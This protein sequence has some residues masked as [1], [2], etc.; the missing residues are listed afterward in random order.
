MESRV[1]ELLLRR[2]LITVEQLRIALAR[3]KEDRGGLVASLLRLGLLAEDDLT[4]CLRREYR[5]PVVD[6]TA[7][8]PPPEVLRLLPGEV[9]RRHR[10]LPLRREGS[11]LTVA[12]SDPSNLAGLNEVKFLS[13]CDVRIVLSPHGALERALERFYDFHRDACHEA[14]L[15]LD[16]SVGPDPEPPAADPAE[17]RRAS[18]APPLVKFLDALLAAAVEK[19]ASDI[20]I[21][22]YEGELR[23]RFRIDGA[24]RE[25]LAPPARLGSALAS[26]I[27]VMAGLDIAERRR[28]QD[29]A[30]SVR[31][32]GGRTA[33]FRVSVLPTLHGETVVLRLLDE[34]HLCVDLGT[35]GFEPQALECFRRGI[36]EP[37]GMVLVTGPTGS[38]KSTT[39]YSALAEIDRVTRNVCSVEDPVELRLRGVNQVQVNEEAGLTFA[40]AL[41]ALLRQDPDVILVGEIRDAETASIAVQA[42]LTGHLVLSTLHTNDAPS[43]A[44]RLLE[45]GVEPFR[46]ASSVHLI[47]AQ[48]LVRRLC[49]GCAAAADGL[50]REALEDIGVPR[51][52]LGDFAPLRARGCEECGRSGYRGRIALYEVMPVTDEIR[53][54]LLRH[55]PAR[56]VRRIAVAQGMRTLRQA[57]LLRVRE[58]STTIEEVVRT[59]PRD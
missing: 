33:S 59:T 13:G 51:S 2:S 26:R 34:S 56:E 52:E 17:L 15:E 3:R 10:M 27:K 46:V 21:E 58:G 41:R 38:G 39:M 45:M 8:E 6:P 57:G 1:G 31:L 36:A 22:P 25:V 11:T 19:Q 47:V 16:A 55:A 28:P 53:S 29:G 12:T 14:L 9:A 35:L 42:A 49:R 24:L 5:L 37:H 44:N 18:E 7:A 50:P 40:A 32:P 48:R 4:E 54:A 23:V 30:L 43:T 20:H